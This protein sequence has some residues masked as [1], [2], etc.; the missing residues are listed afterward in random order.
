MAA[1][2]A[3]VTAVAWLAALASSI[4]A[5][6]RQMAVRRMTAFALGAFIA[7]QITAAREAREERLHLSPSASF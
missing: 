4:A 3:A 5:A 2:I 6:R 7:K 1:G